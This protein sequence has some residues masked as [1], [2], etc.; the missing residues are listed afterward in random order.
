[1]LIQ[2]PLG[3]LCRQSGED[4]RVIVRIARTSLDLLSQVLADTQYHPWA[5]VR[6]R[7]DFL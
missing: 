6:L 3:G 1:M 2:E 7:L 5:P 4:Y